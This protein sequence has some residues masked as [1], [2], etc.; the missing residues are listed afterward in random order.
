M[1]SD[2]RM[3]IPVKELV[4]SLLIPP[5]VRPSFAGW[6]SRVDALCTLVLQRTIQNAYLFHFD[7]TGVAALQQT[8]TWP[9]IWQRKFHSPSAPEALIL[10]HGDT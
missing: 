10:V 8:R 9:L 5:D 4:L 7:E 3:M 2:L 1:M 6:L